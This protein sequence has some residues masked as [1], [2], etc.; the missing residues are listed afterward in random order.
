[1]VVF[2]GRKSKFYIMF[3]TKR[4]QKLF[5]QSAPT[6]STVLIFKPLKKYSSRGAIP[7]SHRRCKKSGM[8]CCRRVPAA[9]P[10]NPAP[11][12]PRGGGGRLQLLQLRLS[13]SQ[14]DRDARTRGVSPRAHARLPLPP[15]P[16]RLPYEEGAQDAHL[17]RQA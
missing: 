3:F 6:E 10:P 12:P 8:V 5:K 17:P 14:S 11:L 13:I 2:Y 1:L 4:L 15:L 7:L 16:P 9:G